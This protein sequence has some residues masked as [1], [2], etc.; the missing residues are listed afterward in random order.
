MTT[1][2]FLKFPFVLMNSIYL[3][4]QSDYSLSNDTPVKHYRQRLYRN[5]EQ[6]DANTGR[7]NFT[8]PPT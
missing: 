8:P 1:A 3:R 4:Q 2:V 6:K 5:H 7:Q